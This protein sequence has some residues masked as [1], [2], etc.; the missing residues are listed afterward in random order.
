MKV[1]VDPDTIRRK[2]DRVKMWEVYNHKSAYLSDHGAALSS[3]QQTEYD[4]TEERYRP[5]VVT[6]FS[7]NMLKGKPLDS[8]ADEGRWLP[9][10]PGT[11]S[12]SLW[13]YACDKR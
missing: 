9:I 13:K 6:T 7:G 5:L 3:R 11:V 4:C 10:P 8:N 2:G 1:Y 12:K